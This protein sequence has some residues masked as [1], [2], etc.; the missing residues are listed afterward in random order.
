MSTTYHENNFF[1]ENQREQNIVN[2]RWLILAL[3]NTTLQMLQGASMTSSCFPFQGQLKRMT[4]T[5]SP[6]QYCAQNPCHDVTPLPENEALL[7]WEQKRSPTW[8]QRRVFSKSKRL[9]GW[10][11]ASWCMFIVFKCYRREKARITPFLFVVPV[12]SRTALE[13]GGREFWSQDAHFC[14]SFGQI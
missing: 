11:R 1:V 5:A 2:W 14:F 10:V 13:A 12:D 9:R 6:K 4:P 7:F 8:S 3:A